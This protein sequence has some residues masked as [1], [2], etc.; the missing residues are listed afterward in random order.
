MARDL[1]S[2][3]APDPIVTDGSG[4]SAPIPPLFAGGGD[5][6]LTVSELNGRIRDL[7]EGSYPY[8]RVRGEIADLRRPPSGH[9]YFTLIDADSQ[10]RSVVWRTTV[11]RLPLS[12]RVGDAVLVTGRVSVYLPRG[13][14]QLVVEGMLP[15]GAGDE[16]E[17]LLRL[18][19]LLAAEGLFAEARKR[20]L[21][22]LPE[23]I[24]VVTS[25]AGAAIHDIMRVLDQRFPGY[26]LLLAHAQVQGAA[27]PEEIAAALDRLN[28]DA[29]AAVIICGRGG[30]SA[31]DLAAFNS[32]LVVR[33]IARSRAPVI[34][35]VGHE[36]DITLA[37][38]VADWRCATPS[39]AAERVLPEKRLLH[40]QLQVL[41][42][43]LILATHHL[44][45]QQH[46]RVRLQRARL[47]DP[48]R[49]LE[50]SRQRCDEAVERLRRALHARL[51]DRRGRLAQ[52]QERLLAWR[53]G[54][55]LPFWRQRIAI[56]LTR[57]LRA[58]P[59]VIHARGERLAALHA[60]L[61]VLS[62]QATLKR[63]FAIVRDDQGQLVRDSDAVRPGDAIALTLA[64]G[65]M[66]AR[67]TRCE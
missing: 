6:P 38:L 16:R 34:S 37:D 13:E 1:F 66:Q 42:E 60:R 63:G 7:L 67:V 17:R 22:F 15:R 59:E 31:E 56:D 46:E 33:A 52:L 26:H 35:A 10:I 39:A 24:G 41:Q 21:P 44:L 12:P 32:E 51:L 57:L 48:R 19:A 65:G 25:T 55:Y 36:V 30:G 43:R 45:R 54:R 50:H 27:A 9:I 47:R 49:H 53:E 28:A 5:E 61:L 4:E 2:D 23:V 14:Y 58:G 62:P 8:V 3:L 64:R 18:H 20:P 40:D 11:R 29:R